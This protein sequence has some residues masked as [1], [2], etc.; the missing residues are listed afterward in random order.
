MAVHAQQ[1]PLGASCLLALLPAAAQ[2]RK[3]PALP[4]CWYACMLVRKALIPADAQMLIGSQA[5]AL[6]L[7]VVAE[8]DL[9]Q[10][11]RDAYPRWLNYCLWVLSEVQLRP[12]CT[13]SRLLAP[14]PLPGI[15][16]LQGSAVPRSSAS[17][18]FCLAMQ[19]ATA[20]H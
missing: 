17:R 14:P 2:H 7:G 18:S 6:K 19:T 20:F 10:C 15:T 5:L 13:A 4:R 9:A 11:C 12:S 3:S 8:R 16:M 1:L